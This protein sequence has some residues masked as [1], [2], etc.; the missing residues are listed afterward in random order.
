MATIKSKVSIQVADQQPDFVQADHPDFLQF[1]KAYYEFLE[2][3]ELKLYNLGSVSSILI[4]GSTSSFI[5][6]ENLNR[7]RTG[8]E[9]TILLEDTA[10]GAFV[11][12]ETIVGQTSKATATIR[13]E[14]IN[15]NSRLFISAENKFILDEQIVGQTSNASGYITSYTA[16]P[17]QNIVQLMEYYDVDQT[18]DAFF[19]EF[20]E[21]FMRTLPQKLTAGIKHRNLLKNIKDLYRAKG[22]KGGHELF[23]RILLGET[24][25]ITYPTEK[26]LR[27]SA[28][29]WS[30]DTILRIV[31]TN[32][33]VEMENASSSSAIFPLMEDG[34]QILL[35]DSTNGTSDL[36]KLVGQTITQAAVTDLTIAP[37][38]A[39]SGLGYPEIG[40]ATAVVDSVFQYILLGETITEFVLNP[41][42][43]D[44]TFYVGHNI[45]GTDNTN[46]DITLTGKIISIISKADTTSANFQS[47]QY[48]TTAD[49]V[50]ISAD[51]GNDAT[52]AIQTVTAGEI[53]EFV[54][55]VPG[56]GYAVGDKLVVNNTNTNGVNLAGEVSMVNGGFAPETGTLTN[57]FRIT[58]EDGTPGAPGEILMEESL[59]TYETPTGT[60]QI[61]ETITG[62][63]SAATGTVVAVE[64]DVKHIFYNAVSGT[65]TLG[66]EIIG[67]TS[68]YKATLLTNTVENFISNEEDLGMIAANRFILEGETTVADTYQ[69]EAI[70]QEGDTG[71]LAE[72]RVT[73]IGYGYTAPPT[74]T[75]TSSGGSS[76]SV[77]AKGT[78]VG[79]IS[80]VN[81][82]EQGAHYTDDASLK[83]TTTTNFLCT[84][85]SGTFVSNETVTGSTS[86]ATARFKSQVNPIGVIKMDTLSTTPFIVGETITGYNSSQ[87][88]I[89]NSFTKSNIPGSIGTV[90]Q[91]SGKYIGETG[92]LDD[93]SQRI[94]DS[95]YYQDFSYVVKTASSIVDWRDE[96]LAAVHPAG[97]AVFG[98]VDMGG[99]AP[100][101]GYLA[102]IT[103]I[104]GLGPTY[105]FIWNALI[106]RRLG[107]TDQGPIN[108]T[109]QSEA[110]EPQDKANLYNPALKVLPGTA[111]TTYETITGGTSGATGRVVLDTT[112]D[113]GVRIIT[114]EPDSGI[115]QAAEVITGSTSGRT[116]TI[117]EVYGL[118]GKRDVTLNHVMDIEYQ[119]GPKGDGSGAQPDYNNINQYMFANSMIQ[120]MTSSL[121]FRSHS[122]YT[123]PIPISTLN[124]AIDSSVT[125]ITVTDGTNYPAAGTIQIGS[126][127]I[128]YTGKST[129]DLTGCT[130]GQHSTTAAAHIDASRVDSVRWAINQSLSRPTYR[131]A[132][133]LTDYNNTTLTIGDI[134][135]Y[136]HRRNDISTPTEVTL[137]KT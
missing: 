71:P 61:G 30:E 32:D 119:M 34:S 10:A 1:L 73:S 14:D 9:N 129:N 27:V 11:N 104:T 26:M 89:I 7:Y 134:T 122:V 22:T 84:S 94:Q 8:E 45:T 56:T 23:F 36:L 120:S 95:Y 101:L 37:G 113:E 100:A 54:V 49:P 123:V 53:K 39:Y 60:F 80:S 16:N 44:G 58:L 62:N 21:A 35:Q 68:G 131:M 91:R 126:E 40:V 78:N 136:P 86:G 42:S 77:L 18:I 29:K 46:T 25:N 47:S 43:I 133:W 65:F 90:V 132:D 51:T 118:R 117:D 135:N 64:T 97:W 82:I 6:Q 92:F 112:T 72:V 5:V 88:A 107:T 96:L 110:N 75:I 41:G 87:T 3:G 127:L 121:T 19:T 52:A 15:L 48:A 99:N 74:L 28:G 33:T 102:N 124:G 103:S 70:T 115:F 111:F 59:I 106:G 2:T 63:T 116:T 76:G 38:G 57:E 93:S 17:I 81:I 109:P 98:E 55:D 13:V 66:E 20:K 137:Y 105:K 85:I 4:E 83:F 31:A 50:I 128:D 12:G 79:T 24:A 67:G 114:Y 108:P 69:G 125:T 130:R